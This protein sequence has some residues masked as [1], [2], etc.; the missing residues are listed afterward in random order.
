M[1]ALLLKR[2]RDGWGPIRR[3]VYQVDLTIER[4]VRLQPNQI[5]ELEHGEHI[6]TVSKA[7][8]TS[9]AD[10]SRI[11]EQ[12]KARENNITLRSPQAL[13]ALASF[14]D[15]FSA[16]SVGIDLSFRYVTNAEIAPER[17][18]PVPD[19]TPLISKWEQIRTG[20]STRQEQ[21]AAIK[22]IRD[23]LSTA[24]KPE[25]LKGETWTD[26]TTFIEKASDKELLVFIG[27]I[28]WMTGQTNTQEMARHIQEILVTEHATTLHQ[29]QEFYP[30]LFLHVFKL[31]STP[32]TKRLTVEDRNEQL[33]LPT[34]SVADQLLL[35]NLKIIVARLNERVEGLEEAVSLLQEQ[36]SVILDQQ[37]QVL[38]QKHGVDATVEYSVH[39]RILDSPP[40]VIP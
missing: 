27:K 36:T 32:G 40:L 24:I 31:L 19:K 28:E 18:S 8:T 29:A 34:L 11:L 10:Q 5:L 13:E 9:G 3:F 7:I 4:W 16:N 39:A 33:A 22:V 25:G 30:R 6:D 2:D 1:S 23:F 35:D 12:I 21:L 37:V 26:F 15:H 14:H 20:D 38:A 17:P